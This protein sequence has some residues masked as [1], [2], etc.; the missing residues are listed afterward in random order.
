[1]AYFGHVAVSEV[2]SWWDKHHPRLFAPN[3]RVFLGL[4]E[5]NQSII[6]TLE[7][8]PK[9]FWY[10]NNGITALCGS[11]G[12]KPI[13]GTSHDSGVFEC[14]DVRI[15]NGAQTVGAIALANS[16][17]PEKAVNATVMV[18]F[19]SL[20]N[21]PE[22][23]A[24]QVTRATNTQNRIERRD[25]V[26]LDS[27]QERLRT[28][29]QLE[30]VNYSYKAADSPRDKKSGF[31]LTEATI[32]LACAHSDI[33]HAMQAKR[34][35]S[36][37]WEDITKAPYKAL[38][39]SGLSSLRLWRLVQIHRTIDAE[40]KNQ[41]DSRDGREAMVPVH[42]NR[43]IARQVFQRP[44]LKDLDDPVTDLTTVLNVVQGTTTHATDLTIAAPNEMYPDSYI[45]STF[46]NFGK[47]RKIEE[48]VQSDW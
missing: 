48:R 20:E 18:R 15:V 33:S 41:E 36:K 4:T 14:L 3:L 34:E 24:V 11:I 2:A 40:L 43:F 1:L 30:G 37:L 22:G 35:I 38:F 25:F 26:S 6:E 39:N 44:S 8:S 16:K 28:E 9:N 29:L 31:D 19:I 12:K 7:S 21:C 13:G 27:E 46:K 17:Y 32:A 23:F 42:G 47:C 5:I 10:S 45:A